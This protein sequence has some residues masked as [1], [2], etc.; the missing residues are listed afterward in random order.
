MVLALQ[1]NASLRRFGAER[2]LGPAVALSLIRELGPVLTALMVVARAGSAMTAEIGIMRIS[3]QIDALESMAVDPTKY[4][5]S[6]RLVGALLSVPLLSAIFDVVGIYGGYLVA[7]KLL[8][9]A[10]DS[11]FSSMRDAVEASD[12]QGGLC[13]AVGFAVL[14]AWVCT[15]KGFHCRPGAAGVARATTEAVVLSS[16]L[17]LVADYVLTSILWG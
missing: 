1:G 2:L 17:V 13:K 7:V 16:V 14:I 3:E 10:G 12:L 11:Y 6:P 5:V 4:L 8:G 9:V 15:W